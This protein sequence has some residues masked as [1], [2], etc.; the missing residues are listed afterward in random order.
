MTF[1]SLELGYLIKI[2]KKFGLAFNTTETY[3]Q[4]QTER[5]WCLFHSSVGGERQGRNESNLIL[6]LIG[7]ILFLRCAIFCTPVSQKFSSSVKEAFVFLHSQWMVGFEL[8]LSLH[9]CQD[10]CVF[11][12]GIV[13]FQPSAASFTACGSWCEEVWW[14]VLSHD[15][16]PWTFIKVQTPRKAAVQTI[17]EMIYKMKSPLLKSYLLLQEMKLT[18]V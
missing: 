17:G 9:R 10:W 3:I 6:L 5:Q 16:L 14:K 12:P 11:F 15:V 4:D 8:S 2:V 1:N 18:E 7:F 13:F